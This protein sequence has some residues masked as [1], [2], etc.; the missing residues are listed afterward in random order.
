MLICYDDEKYWQRAGRKTLDEAQAEAVQLC[1]ELNQRGQY[2]L[3]SPLASSDTAKTVRLRDGEPLI[4]DGPYA[5]T[6]EVLGGFY[7]IEASDIDDA[8]TFAARHPGLR[9]GAVEVRPLTDLPGLPNPQ[10]FS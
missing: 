3:A 2:I 5:E 4:T 6:R 8:L 7:L 1:Q 9:A 10:V